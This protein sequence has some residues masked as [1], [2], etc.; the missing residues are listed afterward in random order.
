M[1]SA[2]A[3][4]E[5]APLAQPLSFTVPLED[6]AAMA[7][8]P[9]RRRNEVR[10][11]LPLLARVRDALRGPDARSLHA[12]CKVVAAGSRH[13]MRGLSAGSLRR[14]Y[15][16]YTLE[17]D[18]RSLVKGYKG[19]NKQPDEFKKELQRVAE[20]NQCSVT[21]ALVRIRE[22]WAA[23]ESIPGYGTW[24]ENYQFQFP[25][26]PL[27]KVWP[28]GWYPAGWSV[29][30]LRRYGPSK[31][32]R[33]LF[34]RGLAAARKHFPSVRRDPSQLR[35]LE[36]IVIDDFELDC[37]CAFRGDAEHKPQVGRVAGLLAIDVATRRK[38]H[39]GLGQRMERH[40]EQPDGTVKT[41]RT[42]IARIDVQLLIHGLFAKFGLPDYPVT[43]LC[44]N[45]AAAISPELELSLQTLFS[46][47]VRVERTGL[48][49]H[50]NL[51]NGFVERGGKPWEKG[52]I[53]AAF[54][55]LWNILG[56]QK[57][58]KGNNQ[59]LNAPGDLDE[60]LRHTKL[61]L[62]QGERKLNLPPDQLALLRLP[63]QT[64]EE[65]ERAFA[66][67]CA[68]ADA[69]DNHH[70][71]GFDRVT[72]FLLEEGTEPQPFTALALLPPERQTQVTLIERMESPVERWTRLA[73]GVAFTQVDQAALAIF[74]LTPK[75]CVYRDHAI[76]FSHERGG[77]RE[78]FSFVDRDGNVLRDAQEGTEFLGYFDP[79]NPERLH[80]TQLNGARTG[81]LV[82]LGGKT[83]MID[84]RDKDSLRAAAAIR[85]TLVNR[86]VAHNRSLHAEADILA[87][88]EREHNA[89]IVAAHK[90]ATSA[91]TPI[92][93]LALAVGED[94]ARA[95][96]ERKAEAAAQRGISVSGA[97]RGLAD[98]VPAA[99]D[100]SSPA[101][102]PPEPADEPIGLGDI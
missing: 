16:A 58:Y 22:R 37:L 71:I 54:A 69:R 60:K 102:T 101:H 62:G 100:Q 76:T 33:V 63:F 56:S 81:T 25:E 29:R 1:S 88:A 43:I 61:L 59:R 10:V 26:R 32:A 14:K 67:A 82:R 87:G 96:A 55:Q 83:G 78:G 3:P 99:A 47:R 9:E 90:A 35:P 98:L 86:V 73:A 5:A 79:A 38:L 92:Q 70:Y 36:L 2:L 52:W 48:I 21:E 11:L 72:E 20:L 40:E 53:E 7:E 65:L 51:T 77:K 18:W 50:R 49:E 41:V 19:P 17:G 74:L 57:G 27:P 75:R 64:P 94:E 13:L 68:L 97:S 31:G 28:R 6:L 30:N 84:I 44:E 46:G 45:A 34:T 15:E 95:H 93:K 85:E 8:L 80:I 23:G 12:A 39:W 89:A 42:G 66:W 4:I 24:L 91:L